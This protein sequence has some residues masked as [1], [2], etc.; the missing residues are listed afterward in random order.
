L[1]LEHLFLLVLILMGEFTRAFEAVLQK[2]LQ[3]PFLGSPKKW[4]I[5]SYVKNTT[6]KNLMDSADK[7]Y[8]APLMCLRVAFCFCKSHMCLIDW[9]H[10]FMFRLCHWHG[11]GFD[12]L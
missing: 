10:G 1:L 2:M 5:C 8:V 3:V 9:V 4:K 12:H 6:C 7:A 11:Q